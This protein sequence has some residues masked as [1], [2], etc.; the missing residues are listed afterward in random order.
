MNSSDTSHISLFTRFMCWIAGTESSILVKYPTEFAKFSIIGSVIYMTFLVAC[1]S[2]F[3]AAY[4]FSNNVFTSIFFAL[5]WGIV[6]FCID[7]ALV[8]TMKKK[9]TDSTWKDKVIENSKI[10]VPRFILA[11]LVAFLMSIPLELLVFE[12]LIQQELPAYKEEKLLRANQ[13][14]YHAQERQTASRH[15][16]ELRNDSRKAEARCDAIGN[17]VT[18]SQS[19]IAELESQISNKRHQLNNPTTS[20]DAGAR[21]QLRIL[22]SQLARLEDDDPARRGINSEIQAQQSI[23]NSEVATWNIRLNKEIAHLSSKLPALR[24]ELNNQKEEYKSAN[25]RVKAAENRISEVVSKINSFTE[26]IDSTATTI[27]NRFEG[28]NKFIQ[29]YS[30]L[31]YAISAKHEEVI[32]SADGKSETTVMVLNNPQALALLW[33]IRIIF[34]VFEMMPT[35]VKAVSKPGPYEYAVDA[36]E[37]SVKSYLL[38]DAYRDEAEQQMLNSLMHEHQLTADRQA[39]EKELHNRLLSRICDA[40]EKIANVAIENWRKEQLKVS[41]S[42]NINYKKEKANRGYDNPSADTNYNVSNIINKDE[43]D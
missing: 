6:I 27:S 3:S 13:S 9:L 15:E 20:R 33:F 28:S 24:Q 23:I 16:D 17:E 7:R 38:S 43:W 11:I 31:D 10:L 40:Q 26:A 35:V 34:I 21:R 18:N 32:K 14:G 4:Y 36:H 19:R 12:D 41:A 37:Q 42:N 5:F 29:Y 39:A 1:V 30:V 8:V 25:E 22:N 2:G